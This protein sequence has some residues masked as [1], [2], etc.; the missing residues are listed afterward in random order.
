MQVDN[1]A[2][3]G[4]NRLSLSERFNSVQGGGRGGRP[5]ARGGYRGGRGGKT[6]RLNPNRPQ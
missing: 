5:N 2:M 1:D 6:L 4:S 3:V